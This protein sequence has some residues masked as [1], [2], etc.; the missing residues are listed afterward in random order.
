MNKLKKMNKKEFYEISKVESV[1]YSQWGGCQ[2]LENYK[3]IIWNSED[4]VWDYYNNENPPEDVYRIVVDSRKSCGM[5]KKFN[6]EPT[7]IEK[8]ILLC[9]TYNGYLKGIFLETNMKDKNKMRLFEW[10]VVCSVSEDNNRLLNK[11]AG[12]FCIGAFG[13]NMKIVEAAT[14]VLEVKKTDEKKC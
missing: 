12:L 11:V 4:N 13:D 8:A 6:D 10:T 3:L 9:E 2:K 1:C 7:F 5:V 14:K